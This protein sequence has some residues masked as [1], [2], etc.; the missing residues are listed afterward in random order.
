MNFLRRSGS[1]RAHP[2]VFLIAMLLAFTHLPIARAQSESG[3]PPPIQPEWNVLYGH[4]RF[5][6][7]T[8]MV[9]GYIRKLRNRH[10]DERSR[11]IANLKTPEQLD[12]YQSETRTKLQAALGEFPARSPLKPRIAGVAERGDYAIEKIIFESRP[13]YFVTA[14]AYVPRRHTGPYPAVLAPV[15]HWGLGK[16]F[17]EYQRLGAYLARRGYLALVYDVPGQ[18]ERRQYFNPVL[19]RAL[20]DPGG[21]HWFVTLEHGYAGG[22]TILTSGNY[23]SY[24]VWDG[25][26]A[27]DYLTQRKDVDPQRLACTGTSGGGLQTELLS[28]IDDRIKVSIPVCYGGCNPIT[29]R[30]PA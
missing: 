24:L 12:R 2:E 22:Q 17:E 23:A 9:P 1:Q 3:A 27:L 25:I 18:G 8:R 6:D 15:G 16:G 13:N 29:P 30:A 26:R 21:S 4:E 19:R 5:T 14:N 28:A 10:D 11:V 7:A 20:I